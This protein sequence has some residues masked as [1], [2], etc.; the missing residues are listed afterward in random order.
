MKKGKADMNRVLG[1]LCFVLAVGLVIYSVFGTVEDDGRESEKGAKAGRIMKVERDRQQ[2]RRGL[3]WRKLMSEKREEGMKVKEIRWIAE[4]FLA[5]GLQEDNVGG[6]EDMHYLKARRQRGDWLA[7]AIKGAYLP[8]EERFEGVRVLIRKNED[9][10]FL[11]FQEYLG[12]VQSFEHEGRKYTIVGGPKWNQFVDPSQWL[13]LEEYDIFTLL[14]VDKDLS[15]ADSRDSFS[16]RIRDEMD[17]EFEKN[18]G[19]LGEYSQGRYGVD[20][21]ESFLPLSAGQQTKLMELSQSK[22]EIGRLQVLHPS[23]LKYL[24]LLRPD[25][26]EKVLREAELI[27]GKVA[28]E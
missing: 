23:Q 7:T 3:E 18:A 12:G 8:S 22:D 15:G 28:G 24:M 11:R 1:L 14:Q 20:Q 4:D 17:L 5:L 2:S 25:M 13:E 19:E 27:E 10:A 16:V 21:V 9:E 26:A 6:M